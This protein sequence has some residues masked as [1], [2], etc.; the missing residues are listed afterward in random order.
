MLNFLVCS[1]DFQCESQFSNTH[2]NEKSTEKGVI[3]TIEILDSDS[4][5]ML[6]DRIDSPKIQRKY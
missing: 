4:E 2:D 6:K 5:N 3:E 1:E